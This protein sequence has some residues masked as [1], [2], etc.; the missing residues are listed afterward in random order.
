VLPCTAQPRRRSHEQQ[1]QVAEEDEVR[2]PFAGHLFSVVSWPP[3]SAA[4]PASPVEV[5]PGPRRTAARGRSP[6]RRRSPS[7]GRRRWYLSLP[8]N[9]N[10]QRAI[11]MLVVGLIGLC[12]CFSGRNLGYRVRRPR[13][14]LGRRRQR[15]ARHPLPE[16]RRRRRR[17][18]RP[19]SFPGAS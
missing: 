6:P 11:R 18:K 8:A 1:R 17:R 15:R 5:L 12:M 14:V 4:V 7:A 9:S 19:A 2:S 13:R 10:I 3:R 16:D